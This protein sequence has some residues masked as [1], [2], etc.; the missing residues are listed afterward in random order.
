MKK[1]ILIINILFVT[2]AYGGE[3]AEARITLLEHKQAVKPKPAVKETSRAELKKIKVQNE[4]LLKILDQRSATPIIWDGERKFLTGKTLR[5]R[6]LNSIVSTNLESPVLVE[7]HGGQGLPL[8]SKFSCL[9]STKHKRVVTTC[10][11]LVT[12]SKEIPVN[13]QVL[14]LDGTSG[15]LGSYEDGKEELIAG[16]IVTNATQGLLAAS[17]GYA[18][19]SLGHSPRISLKNQLLGGAMNSA[20]AT[21]ELLTE[22]LKTKEPI[23]SIDAGLEVLVYFQ[24]AADVY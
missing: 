18:T 7:V 10:N 23:V 13:V 1:L 2:L 16:I 3:E 5:G 14:N 4:A 19:T 17:E 22:D 6:L 12:S 21:S 20:K 24:E 9:G 15:L 11:K 8:K